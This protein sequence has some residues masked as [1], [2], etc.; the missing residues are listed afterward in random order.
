M[1]TMLAGRAQRGLGD[2]PCPRLPTISSSAPA[3]VQQGRP[4]GL[5]EGVPLDRHHL[6]RHYIADPAVPAAV[7]TGGSPHLAGRFAADGRRGGAQPLGQV[8]INYGARPGGR[9]S[10]GLPHFRTLCRTG[11]LAGRLR[12]TDDG[13]EVLLPR[14]VSLWSGETDR[15]VMEWRA[16]TAPAGCRVGS[17]E[18]SSG[19]GDGDEQR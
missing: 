18:S 9:R 10:R 14:G 12:A 6:F 16:L 13:N 5:V 15:L 2:P 1:H 19:R 4:G 17:R 7:L 3:D 11:E 8:F